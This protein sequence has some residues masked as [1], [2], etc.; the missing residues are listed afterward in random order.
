M[1]SVLNTLLSYTYFCIRPVIK[2]LLRKTTKL[3]ELQRICYGDEKGARRTHNVEWSLMMSRSHTIK[4]VISQLSYLS[5]T[6]RFTG[7]TS[8]DAVVY[9]VGVISE[10]K[11]INTYIHRPF[12][13]SLRTCLLQI[14]GYRQLIYEVENMRKIPYSSDDNSHEEKLLKLW[15]ELQPNNPLVNRISKQWGDVGF[16]GDDPKTDFRGMGLLGLENLLFFATKHNSAARHVLSHSQHPTYGYPFAITGINLTSMTYQL[17][18]TDKL[19]NHIYNTVFNRASI[20]D[21]HQA[22]CYVFYEFDKFW[23][24]EKPK[25]VME[26][27]R[28]RDKFEDH[29]LAYLSKYKAA[30][31][32]NLVVET[33]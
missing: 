3:C 10:V 27:N 2:W 4:N 20:T 8:R 29:L 26:F 16:Q 31:K 28:I 24:K 25:D 17:L 33:L 18:I 21:F 11:N 7:Q 5:E 22:Y 6:G 1:L 32:L 9:V 14:Y 30:L 12:V 13:S 19:K 23:L 15:S